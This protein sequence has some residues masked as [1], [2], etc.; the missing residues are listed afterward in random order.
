MEDLNNPQNSKFIEDLQKASQ[1][2]EVGLQMKRPAPSFSPESKKESS[3]EAPSK[4]SLERSFDQDLVI[5]AEE[6]AKEKDF[7]QCLKREYKKQNFLLK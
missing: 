3:K 5:K 7:Y 6:V 4:S 1:E 2:I